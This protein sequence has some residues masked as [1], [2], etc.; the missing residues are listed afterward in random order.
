MQ[1]IAVLRPDNR[2]FENQK[3]LEA[4]LVELGIH[5]AKLET[6]S[7]QHQIALF[8]QAKLIVANHGAALSNMVWCDN[9]DCAIIEVF[10][11]LPNHSPKTYE[12]LANSLGFEYQA[13]YGAS[14]KWKTSKAKFP[15]RLVKE[16]IREIQLKMASH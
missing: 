5:V 12:T 11:S 7:I 13:V 3:A 8:S 2:G 15:L 1:F 14:T 16:K 4:E 10:G 6:S 9:P